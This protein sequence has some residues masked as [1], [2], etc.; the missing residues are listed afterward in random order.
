MVRKSCVD[1]GVWSSLSAKDLIIPL[2][3]HVANVSRKLKLTTRKANDWQT[4][5]EIT[6]KLRDFDA[7]DPVKYDFALFDIGIEKIVI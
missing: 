7:N 4:A 6:N 1:R 5:E 3:V 2:D